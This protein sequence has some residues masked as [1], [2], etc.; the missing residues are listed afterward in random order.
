[1]IVY[2]SFPKIGGPDIDP[3]WFGSCYEGTHEKSPQ[4]VEEVVY[5]LEKDSLPG[6]LG[7]FPL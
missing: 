4:L 7:P 5:F 6:D 2:G 3:N 1:M